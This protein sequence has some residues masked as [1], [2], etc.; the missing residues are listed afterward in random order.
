[1]NFIKKVYHRRMSLEPLDG[2]IF[3]SVRILET[4]SESESNF[5]GNPKQ[6]RTSPPK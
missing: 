4:V 5:G 1:M 2:G 6:F 3:F